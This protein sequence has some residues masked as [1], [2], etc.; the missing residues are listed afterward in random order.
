MSLFPSYKGGD[1]ITI[2]EDSFDIDCD[3]GLLIDWLLKI[4]DHEDADKFIVALYNEGAL[5]GR[6]SDPEKKL[7]LAK[8]MDIP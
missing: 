2:F 6:S 7:D 3:R 8:I 5:Y 4:Q 1:A